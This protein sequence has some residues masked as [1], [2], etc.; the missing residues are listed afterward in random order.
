[1]TTLEFRIPISPNPSF[2]SQVRLIAQ[3]LARL[4]PPYADAQIAV[5]VGDAPA[6]ADVIDANRW[7]TDYPV[8]W[9]IVPAALYEQL[10]H[11]AW[12]SGMA[13]YID[14][15]NVDVTILCDADTCPVARFDDLLERLE[16]TAPTVAG[17]QAHYTPFRDMDHDGLWTMLLGAIGRPDTPRSVPYSMDV[18]RLQGS[19]PPYFNY[20]FVAFNA[21]AFGLVCERLLEMLLLAC[22]L[23]PSQPFSA[24]V[25]LTLTL[26][27]ADIDVLPLGHAF[28][29]ANDDLLLAHCLVDPAD[30]RV[31]HYLRTDEFNRHDFLT[32]ESR[33]L[34]FINAE[35]R[36]AVSERLRQHILSLPEA[37]Y[38][39]T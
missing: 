2:Y 33:F 20:G 14:P 29:C 7:S 21:A 12:G 15:A 32:S 25:A 38:T 27:Q 8:A 10:P 1:M 31:I 35:K 4:G 39:W 22:R 6:L 19:S 18:D 13:R 37:L 17:L 30:I 9:R 5:A 26:L 11:P 36:N 16:G 24:Q 23:L 3:S 34:A 28:N